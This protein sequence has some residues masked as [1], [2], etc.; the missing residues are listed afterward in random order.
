MLNITQGT[1]YNWSFVLTLINHYKVF[2]FLGQLQPYF[3]VATRIVAIRQFFLSISHNVIN[4]TLYT[5][6]L[7]HKIGS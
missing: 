3:L 4:L 1:Y 5:S 2:E 6:H 7:I